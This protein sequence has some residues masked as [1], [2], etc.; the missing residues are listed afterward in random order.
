VFIK[1][2]HP[3]GKNKYLLVEVQTG[4]ALLKDFEQLRGYLEE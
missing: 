1:Q 2:K 4:K 3:M